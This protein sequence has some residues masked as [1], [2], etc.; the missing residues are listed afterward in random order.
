MPASL[1]I[2]RTGESI[3]LAGALP[4]VGLRDAVIQA[5]MGSRIETTL[6]SRQL[7][8]GPYVR[9]ARFADSQDLLAFLRSFFSSSAPQLFETANDCIR[10]TGCATPRMDEEW[11]KLLTTLVE[12]DK[13]SARW[14]I[15]SSALHFPSYQ[16]QSKLAPEALE[17]LRCALKSSIIYFD[18]GVVGVGKTEQAQIIAA[19]D[20]ILSAGPEARIIVGA[21]PDAVDD[22]K[23]NEE[24]AHKR[25]DSVIAALVL[26]GVHPQQLEP[27]LYDVMPP[28][29][30]A[31]LGRS[32]EMLVK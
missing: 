14:R 22:A 13:L 16:P 11:K 8:A 9:P 29:D 17:D 2:L 5:V 7:K 10:I 24:A 12:D 6:D 19:A 32:I 21:H 23:R 31:N 1:R 3:Q 30:G 18:S 28:P 27:F 26:K 4:G 25:I 20:A 15:F